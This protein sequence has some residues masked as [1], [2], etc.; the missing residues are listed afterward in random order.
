M[1]LC[2][3]LSKIWAPQAHLADLETFGTLIT[4]THRGLST[5][6]DRVGGSLS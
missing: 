5:S 6:C 2:S 1:F 4:N 3:W